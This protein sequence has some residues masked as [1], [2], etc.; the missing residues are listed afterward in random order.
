MAGARASRPGPW[1]APR[2]RLALVA[3]SSPFPREAFLRGLGFLAGRYNVQIRASA[4]H[5]HGYLAGQDQRRADELAIAMTSPQIDA[6]MAIR[7]GYGLTRIVAD[8]PWSAF[9]QAPKLLVGFSDLTAFHL[10]ANVRGIASIHGP[11]VTG[12]GALSPLQKWQ[13]LRLLEYG[14]QPPFFASCE[15]GSPRAQGVGFGGNLAIVAACTEY[16]WR[17]NETPDDLIWFLEDV[18]ER[19]Y[20]IDRMLTSLL[21]WLRRAKAIIFGSFTQC[22]P[23]P[24]GVTVDDVIADL[25]ARLPRVP[26]GVNAPFGHGE[27]NVPFVLGAPIALEPVRRQATATEFVNSARYGWRLSLLE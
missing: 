18:T 11:N 5:R 6:M 27:V 13:L 8:L 10:H 21:P 19:P 24:D 26:I 20:R 12:I 25:R 7:G 17:P 9:A 3:P 2:R 22:E 16:L 14:E 15:E 4:W 1:L 23:G